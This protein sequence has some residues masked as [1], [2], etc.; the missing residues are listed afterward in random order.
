MN[1]YIINDSYIIPTDVKIYYENKTPY[2]EYT[3]EA[4]TNIGKVKVHFPKLDLRLNVIE[5]DKDTCEYCFDWRKKP[6][7]VKVRQQAYVSN[8]KWMTMQIIER[9]MT[10]DQIEK[11]LGYKVNIVEE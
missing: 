10:K 1:E 2:L 7:M 3:G 9:E 6:L 5:N 4:Y 8:D 11:E